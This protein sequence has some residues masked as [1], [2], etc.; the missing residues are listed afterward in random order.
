MTRRHETMLSAA[1]AVWGLAVA[2][3]LLAVFE[4]PAPPDQLPGLAKALGFDA[5]G[6][7]RW[8]GGLMLLPILFPFIL[9]PVARRLADG[10]P[11]AR[12]AAVIAPLVTLWLVTVR[13]YEYGWALGACAVVLA[14]CTL[15]RHR[16]L[17]FTRRDVVLIPTFMTTLLAVMDVTHG[18]H[19]PTTT[20]IY[21]AALLV[22]GLRLAVSFIPSSLPPGLAFIAAPLGLVL[23]TGFFARDQRYFGWHALAVV[24]ITP[25]VLRFLLKDA[26][27]ALA[28]LTFAI[29]PIALYSYANAVGT[30]TAEGQ[31]RANFF[32]DGHALLP[33]SEYLRGELPYRDILPAHGLFED[34]YFDY[35]V[36]RAGNVSIGARAKA[37]DVAGNLACVAMYFLA[38]AATGSAEGAFF[39][40]LLSFLSGVYRVHVRVVVPILTLACIAFAVRRRRWRWFAVAGLGCV[41]CGI[42]SLDF[43]AYTFLTLIVAVLRNRRAL[44]PA[45]IGLAAGVIP[46]AIILAAG[47]I[48]DDFVR[49]TF[50]ETLAAG[51]A[52]TLNFFTPPAALA[53]LRAF[54]DVLAALL[55]RDSFLYLFWC[56]AVVFVGVTVT[57]RA[58]RRLEPIVLIGVW[59]VATAISYAERHHLYFGMVAAVPIVYLVLRLLRRQRALATVAIVALVALSSLTSHLG[60]VGWSRHARGPLDEA[61][62]EI[63]NLPRAHGAYFHEKDA[64]A[65]ASAQKYV[66]LSLAPDETFFDFTN[67]GLLY[68]LLRRDCPIREY[69]VAFYESEALQREVIRRIETNPK[70]KAVLVPPTPAG[71]FTIDGVPN[72]DRAPLVWQY[73]RTR[74]EPD[75][76]E[77]DV[78]FW[79]RR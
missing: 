41:V 43:A 66:S 54:P 46:L 44:R 64:A 47:G 32:E 55:D 7:F 2:I 53:K 17:H 11:W 13:H 63:P 48:L 3:A 27:R 76:A 23:Q 1:F 69:E 51:P 61:W 16:E 65:V 9:R 62:V 74:F 75:F 33:A 68:F 31:P 39:A 36:M 79:R 60:I 52:Y 42:I 21:I 14:A 37:R 71:R 72:A 30:T 49:G 29:Y 77:G 20:A 5:D 19:T 45:A 24:V 59:I 22:F 67:S 25:L 78:V 58:S 34:G 15:L 70:V 12:N 50:I 18:S 38:L 57:K 26:R 40:V 6:P 28:I 10:L 8:I 4:H 73:L 35:L 56:A